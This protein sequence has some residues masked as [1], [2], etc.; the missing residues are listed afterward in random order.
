MDLFLVS[1]TSDGLFRGLFPF[2]NTGVK[3][4]AFDLAGNLVLG[5]VFEDALELGSTTLISHGLYDSFVAKCSPITSTKESPAGPSDR[6]L[7]YANPTTGKCN[8]TIPD[9]FKHEKE[10]T[11]YIYDFQGRLVQQAAIKEAEG[12]YRLD[13]RAQAAGI[14]QAV[15]SNGTKRYSGKIVFAKG[16]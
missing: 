9:E 15:L 14:Y 5:G 12:T 8:I 2:I 13:I 16:E 6:L 7:I 10:L 3:C 4:L 1:Y 11:L